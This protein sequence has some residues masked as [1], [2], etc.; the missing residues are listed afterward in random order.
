MDEDSTVE[1]AADTSRRSKKKKGKKK[2]KNKEE[3][4]PPTVLGCENNTVEM[5][6]R[7]VLFLGCSN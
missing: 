5:K 4:S 1:K 6:K 3:A 2:G 7:L